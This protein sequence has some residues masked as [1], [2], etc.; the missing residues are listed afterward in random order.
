[1]DKLYTYTYIYTQTQHITYRQTSNI[2]GDKI[3]DHSDVVVAPPVGAAST[4]SSFST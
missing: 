3:V 1:M 2:R 4:T